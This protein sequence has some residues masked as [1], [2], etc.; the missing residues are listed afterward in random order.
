[1][2][3]AQNRAMLDRF[4]ART[5]KV[6]RHT[7][8]CGA[9]WHVAWRL[10]L[11]RR[12]QIVSGCL[13]S[14][15]I[16]VSVILWMG[17][18]PNPSSASAALPLA[19]SAFAVLCL[20]IGTYQ[21][22][23]TA[24]S[25]GAQLGRRPA[26]WALY[27]GVY[28]TVTVAMLCQ[29]ALW[30]F[31]G[32]NGHL[33]S[34]A[35]VVFLF[36]NLPLLPWH[37]AQ[38]GL[39]VWVGLL[40]AAALGSFAI[41]RLATSC[42]VQ[43]PPRRRSVALLRGG[44]LVLAS[45][46]IS[47]IGMY[48][49][50]GG[51]NDATVVDVN[52]PDLILVMDSLPD[53]SR[54]I[55][56]DRTRAL[57][58]RPNV[59]VVL[60][61]SLRHDLLATTPEAIPF[62]RDMYETHVGFSHAYATASH[63]NLSDLAFWFSQYPLRS[64]GKE[65][66]PRDADWRGVSLFDVF[67]SD[68]YETAYISSQ[69]EMWGGMINW[70]ETPTLDYFFDSESFDG[71]TWE[72]HDD[73]A[74][75]A[76]LIRKGLAQAGKIEDSQTLELAKR[77]I[78]TRNRDRPFFLGMN[79]Q[80]THFSYVTTP[81]AAEPFQPSE[82]DFRAVYYRWPE[83]KSTNVRNRYLNSVLNVDRLLEGFARFLQSRGLWDE[84]VFVVVGDN[85]EAF[86]EHGFGNHSGPMYDEVVRTL[87]VMKLPG[88]MGMDGSVVARPVSH[89][90]ISASI[91][92]ILGLARPW[93]FQ[94]RSVFSEDC[95]SRPV[96]LYSNAIVRQYGIIDWPWKYLVTEFPWRREE[97]YD[98][99]RD[100][101]EAVDV[102]AGHRAELAG[103]RHS[104]ARWMGLQQRYYADSAY[105][106]KAAPDYCKPADVPGPA[107]VSLPRPEAGPAGGVPALR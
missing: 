60:V 77:W 78:D 32:L 101:R 65:T 4:I 12:R 76:G 31:V 58:A 51:A 72:N 26:R 35:A 10:V 61:E 25:A 37:M 15:P 74:G 83:D 57:R 8:A 87:A 89:I 52:H 90:D 30:A 3:V 16:I 80:N 43:R 17:S 13:I 40:A 29:L 88:S 18:I 96:F 79:L 48:R 45:M 71:E 44:V 21:L 54:P 85:G 73:L 67:K 39:S 59:V 28:A 9:G 62:L 107:I 81:G 91:P 11:R 102:A 22:A 20:G 92:E 55:E 106:T 47:I 5:P 34:A 66:F 105:R 99:A 42:S 23:L 38:A 86:Y 93:S 100:P 14:M 98:L 53:R 36:D 75:L 27:A 63:S 69:N 97:L 6:P 49:A 2:Q 82:L 103:L 56:P 95:A 19:C 33:P 84:V 104:L 70:L 24:F 41:V 50:P 7:G 68:G 64:P 46:T 1:V 94:G